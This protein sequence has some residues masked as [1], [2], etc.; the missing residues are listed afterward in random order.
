MVEYLNV[1]NIYVRIDN[2]LVLSSF[3]CLNN[4]I[5]DN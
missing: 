3:F 4:W 5:N 2:C 1:V